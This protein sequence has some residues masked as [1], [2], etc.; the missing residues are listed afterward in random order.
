VFRWVGITATGAAGI[1]ITASWRVRP[2][3]QLEAVMVLRSPVVVMDPEGEPLLA[4]GGVDHECSSTAGE[5]DD[6]LPEQVA[7][8]C[9][10]VADEDA[11]RDLQ[12]P[13]GEVTSQPR[14]AGGE[15]EDDH[16]SRSS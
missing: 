2:A 13:S 12:Q 1:K 8:S 5:F 3:D 6:P 14:W 16:Q 11:R 4:G 7:D 9:R 15:H 10:H